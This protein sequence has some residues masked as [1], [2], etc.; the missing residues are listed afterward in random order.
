MTTPPSQL[1]NLEVWT[2]KQLG[3]VFLIDKSLGYDRDI[4]NAVAEINLPGECLMKKDPKDSPQAFKDK[5]IALKLPIAEA[6]V[7]AFKL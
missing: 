3:R 4:L 6:M 5:I 1:Q 7:R 2:Y